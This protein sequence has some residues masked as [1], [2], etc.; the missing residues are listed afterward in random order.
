[1][2]HTVDFEPYFTRNLECMQGIVV[3]VPNDKKFF[4]KLID[5][6]FNP[7]FNGHAD[8]H[9]RQTTIIVCF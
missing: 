6:H 7:K 5:I 3:A 8:A 2:F 4:Q 1:M 9:K